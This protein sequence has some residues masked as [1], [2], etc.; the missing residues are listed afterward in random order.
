[1]TDHPTAE[2][3]Q[4][5]AEPAGEPARPA[6]EPARPAGATGPASQRPP[7]QI[8][9]SQIQPSQIQPSQIRPGTLPRLG[10]PDR[11]ATPGPPGAAP[12]Q[13]APSR[14]DAAPARPGGPAQPGAAE[15]P[16][17]VQALFDAK[18][19]AWAAKY[20]PGGRLAWR[21]RL[22]TTALCAHTP[23]GSEVLDLGCGSGELARVLA[24]AGWPVTACDISAQML[25][26]AIARDEGGVV[27]WVPLEP[28]W[29]ALPFG[30]GSFDVVIA[31]SVL[32][33]VV[34][35][36]AVFSEC[37]RVLRPGGVVLGT[38]PDLSHPVRW[39]EWLAARASGGQ[40][41]QAAGRHWPL[42]GGYLAYLRVSRQRHRARWWRA[43]AA[44]A[45]LR[46]LTDPGSQVPQSRSPLRL[47]AFGVHGAPGGG[48][49]R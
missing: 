18:A 12:E 27:R 4:P 42:I 40:R 49:G 16:D 33:Y 32:E 23:P 19:A 31:S 48:A 37:A 43:A 10:P 15:A 24:A 41:A 3:G 35:P 2:P 45:G 36:A 34:S 38:V 9:P 44:G 28:G 7:S 17:A 21:V 1:V 6:G 29:R 22:F 5:P 14:G 25:D 11:P 46:P 47:Y 20:A 39:L 26:R 13:D 8:Q 30:A